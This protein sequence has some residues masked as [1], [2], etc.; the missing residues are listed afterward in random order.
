MP[1][2][3]ESTAELHESVEKHP[4]QVSLMAGTLSR[5]AFAEFLGQMWMVH[6]F[7]EAQ[8]RVHRGTVPAMEAVVHDYQF[9]EKH[10]VADLSFFGFELESVQATPATVRLFETIKN[11]SEQAPFA[12][13]GMHYVLEGSTN[14][15]KFVAKRVSAAFGL[16]GPD[17]LRYLDPY[18]DQQRG[19][20]QTFKQS[21]DAQDFNPEQQEM[22]VA[23]A[24]TM[25]SSI[26]AICEDLWRARAA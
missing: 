24:K 4:F 18:G 8:L 10:L 12:L 3:R 25:F 22:L 6:R 16:V 14:G 9:K 23:A 17:G 20:W 19:H 2:L 15:G 21:M 1:R 7:L 5:Q 13:L 11:L 26:G